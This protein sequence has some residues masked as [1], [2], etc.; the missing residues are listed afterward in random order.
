MKIALFA[1]TGKIGSKILMEALNRR[2]IVTAIVRHPEKLTLKHPSLTVVVGNVL[3]ENEVASLAKGHDVVVSAYGPGSNP[4][5]FPLFSKAAQSLVNGAKKAGVRRLINVGGAGS[6]YVAP[7]K[8]LVDMPYFPQSL[9]ESASAQ[10]DSLEVFLKERELD[11]TFFCPA[12]MIDTGTRT[13][14]FRLN[15]DEPVFDP[16]GQSRISTEDFA[17]ALVDEV[18]KPQFIRQRFTVGY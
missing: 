4:A 9:K 3:D 11:W 15:K 18:E 5:N 7:G 17:V 1:A 10:R 6:L 12:I 16:K 2:H 13:G 8:Q 14:K